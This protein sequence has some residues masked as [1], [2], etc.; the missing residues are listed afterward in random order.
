MSAAVVTKEPCHRSEIA[1][2][3][4]EMGLEL[5]EVVEHV[6]GDSPHR[7]VR[8]I[9]PIVRGAGFAVPG[10]PRS[11]EFENLLDH[12]GDGVR[13]V[14]IINVGSFFHHDAP[15]PAGWYPSHSSGKVE[16]WNQELTS[17]WLTSLW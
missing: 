10:R 11:S 15:P 9:D 13:R 2:D 16:V 5:R 6:V 12:L 4:G 8:G 17:R 3:S 1:A 7:L 14:A